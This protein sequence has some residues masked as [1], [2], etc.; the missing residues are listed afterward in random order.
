[1]TITE[2]R[3][4]LQGE[5][6][7]EQLEELRADER[8]GVQKLLISYERRQAK[9]AQAVAQFQNRFSYEKK[10][11]QK[12]QLV[13]GVDEVGRGP[14]AGPVVTAAV[15]LPHNFD[16][17]DVNDSKKLSPKKRKEL[18][19]KILAKAV[20]VS[21]GL[22]NNDVIDRINIYEADRLVMAHAVQGLK[23]KP[24][25]LLVDAMNVP[26]NIPQ[27]KLIHGDAKS[28]SIAAASI[29][30][31]VFR[32]NLMDAYGE[33][34]PEYDFKHNAGYGTREHIEALKKYGPTPIHRRSFAPVS[35]YEK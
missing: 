10:F 17:I 23:V 15:I 1:M 34:Y 2:I 35:E 27:V 28:N 16:L 30:A 9:R 8:K 12:S 21:V 32:D 13:A 33:V 7:S 18:F 25:A 24:A 4:L 22:A 26:L 3:N 5:V 6:S 14:L 29:V 19:P 31:K 20:S 11:W